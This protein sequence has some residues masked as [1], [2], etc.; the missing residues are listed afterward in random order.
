MKYYAVRL[1]HDGPQV[2]TSWAD[3]EKAVK[4]FK[5]AK[6]KSFLTLTDAGEYLNNVESILTTYPEGH[7]ITVDASS[8]IKHN[9]WEF[10]MVW[11]DTKEEIYR[12][13]TYTNGTNNTGEVMGLCYAIKYRAEHKLDC[14]IYTDSMTAISAVEKG[15]YNMK[16][17]LISLDT[18]LLV[19]VMLGEAHDLDR[20]NIIHY[21]NALIGIEIP[22]DY[23]RK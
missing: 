4:G 18:R 12:S 10:R 22:A 5:G 9:F 2:Y 19:M 21:N 13:P 14:N 11:S 8:S 20:E 7:H 1:G 3:C 23:Q 17:N 15:I 6:F 16:S